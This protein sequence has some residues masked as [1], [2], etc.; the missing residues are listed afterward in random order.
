[1]NLSALV[2]LVGL[3]ID[4]SI[5]DLID[6]SRLYDILLIEGPYYLLYI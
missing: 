1:M 6:L 5:R 4:G 3:I 2:L